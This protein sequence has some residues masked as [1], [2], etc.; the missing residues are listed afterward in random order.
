MSS[1]PRS[2]SPRRPGCRCS[3]PAATRW[4]RLAAAITLTVVEPGRTASAPTPSR[5][6][7]DGKQLHGLNASG[8]SPAGWTPERFRADGRCRSAAGTRSPCPA[9]CPRGSSSRASSASCRSRSSSSRRSATAAKASWSRR[10]SRGSGRAGAELQGPARLRRGL[11]AGRPRAARRARGSLSRSMRRRWSRS[12]RRKGE[13]FYRGELAERI[14]AACE[15]ARR[16]ADARRPRRAPA[17]WVEPIAID[18][19]GYTLHEIPP[20][21]QG[22]AA[23]IALGILEQLRPALASRSIRRRQPAPADRGDEARLRRRAARHVADLAAHDVRPP[24]AARR[25]LPRARAK[26]IDM[27]R[28]QDFGHGTPPQAARCTSPRPTRRHDGLVHPVELHG[29]RLG[30]RGARHRHQPAE[31]RRR[32]RRSTPGHPNERRAAASARSTRSFPASS[33]AT[34]SR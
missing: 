33:R 1:P 6:V 22:I 25:G 23:L 5:I 7:W 26:L 16:R 15:A 32:L 21:G 8:R 12:P 18:Y 19:R 31:P 34:A 29:L 3:P 28:A 27:K 13:A 30:R 10:S 4:T 2:R 11:P 14:E 20:N 24:D 17:D 9:P